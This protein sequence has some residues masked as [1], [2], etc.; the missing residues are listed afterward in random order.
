M[1]ETT[2]G[3]AVS[4]ARQQARLLSAGTSHPRTTG[5]R[6]STG[7]RSSWVQRELKGE[8]EQCQPPAPTQLLAIPGPT[9]HFQPGHAPEDRWPHLCR[10][11]HELRAWPGQACGHMPF[12]QCEPGAW[13]MWPSRVTWT[14]F[15]DGSQQS[16]SCEYSGLWSWADTS[17]AVVLGTAMSEGHRAGRSQG[18]DIAYG[19]AASAGLV[20]G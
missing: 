17:V 4:L 3:R 14:L 12:Y 18:L 15:Q 11:L 9:V 1:T 10:T 19:T 7:K 13:D 6:N 8:A 2:P 16:A 20:S 5:A